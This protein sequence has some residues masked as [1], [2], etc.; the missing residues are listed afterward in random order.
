M[1]T[2][3]KKRKFVS[4]PPRRPPP[5]APLTNPKSIIHVQESND[6]IKLKI[7]QAKN[8]AVSQAQQDGCT[9]NFRIFDSP[10]G[11][12]LIPVIP[13]RQELGG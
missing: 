9:A 2:E 11:N 5:R 12:F 4:P 13:T 3:P 8:F 10:Y 6:N 1:S 7:Q